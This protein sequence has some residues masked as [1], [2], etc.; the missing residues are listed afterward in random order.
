MRAVPS[1]QGRRR[2]IEPPGRR[3]SS[4]GAW[5]KDSNGLPQGY[6]SILNFNAA[7]AKAGASQ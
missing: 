1:R 6:R 2:L 7:L 3:A 5:D 4:I